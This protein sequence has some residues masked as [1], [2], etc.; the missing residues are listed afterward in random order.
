MRVADLKSGNKLP[1]YR[2]LLFD[3]QVYFD[4][5]NRLRTLEVIQA[6]GLGN[7]QVSLVSLCG[8]DV[9]KDGTL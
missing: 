5:R 7:L 8:I 4:L 9:A 2:S 1:I 3:H 6:N